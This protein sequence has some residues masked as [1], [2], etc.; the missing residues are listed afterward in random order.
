MG[1][2]SHRV[3]VRGLQLPGMKRTP[4]FPDFPVRL[5]FMIV[6]IENENRGHNPLR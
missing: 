6:E 3:I 1:K 4:K 2:S 5:V